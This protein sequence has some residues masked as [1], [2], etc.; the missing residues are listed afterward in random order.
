MTIDYFN[1]SR[2]ISLLKIEE[3]YDHP[4]LVIDKYINDII[5]N[6]NIH[7]IDNV[8]YINVV[9]TFVYIDGRY[10]DTTGYF[11][12]WVS[13]EFGQ[14]CDK[15]TVHFVYNVVKSYIL[16]KLENYERNRRKIK[17]S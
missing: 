8:V 10:E 14:L 9:R 2:T 5:N 1:Y 11:K 13:L 7:K 16:N 15:Y 12:E 4:I 3:K 6:Y 17:K